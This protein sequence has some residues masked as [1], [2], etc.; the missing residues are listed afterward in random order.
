MQNAYFVHRNSHSPNQQ[1]NGLSVQC[2]RDG[3]MSYVV[4][5][6]LKLSC[7]TFVLMDIFL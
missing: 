4:I 1:K 7:V 6:K 3:L 5:V 2:A